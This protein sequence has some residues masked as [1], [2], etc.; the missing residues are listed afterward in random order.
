MGHEDHIE[1][2]IDEKSLE[3][4]LKNERIRFGSFISGQF[5]DFGFNVHAVGFNLSLILS[6]K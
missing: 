1:V 3:E 4:E 6:F 2:P 5:H